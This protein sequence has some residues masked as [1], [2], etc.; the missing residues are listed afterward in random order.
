MPEGPNGGDLP[1][2]IEHDV[3]APSATWSETWTEEDTLILRCLR[4]AIVAARQKGYSEATLH[5]L[6][7]ELFPP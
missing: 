4:E 3:R 7:H 5:G 1:E 2:R 6:L